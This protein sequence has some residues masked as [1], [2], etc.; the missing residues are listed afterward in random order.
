MKEYKFHSSVM[1]VHEYTL[2]LGEQQRAIDW[3]GVVTISGIGLYERLPL[4]HHGNTLHISIRGESLGHWVQMHPPRRAQAGGLELFSM[5]VVP[6][7]K[8]T[9][10]E[11]PI[12]L[13]LNDYEHYEFLS[14]LRVQVDMLPAWASMV[15][16][17]RYYDVS[18]PVDYY[19]LHVVDTFP[20]LADFGFWF[21]ED[22]QDRFSGSM[23]VDK[24][25]WD[26]DLKLSRRNRRPFDIVGQYVKERLG[27][28]TE[29]EA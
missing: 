21:V 27:T 8:G 11:D 2:D 28:K 23:F 6:I 17:P 14:E 26:L 25:A 20:D 13:D 10:Y 18:K 5:D 19:A 7:A 4:L 12:D 24:F 9:A 29:S 3:H 22:A 15:R 1:R 16:K